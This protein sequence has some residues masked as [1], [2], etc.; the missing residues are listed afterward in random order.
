MSQAEKEKLLLPY[1][2]FSPFP[3]SPP[4]SLL[5]R[6]LEVG[7]SLFALCL[8]CIWHVCWWVGGAGFPSLLFFGVG[9]DS[10][11][12]AGMPACHLPSLSPPSHT[13]PPCRKKGSP[14]L[15]L[16]PPPSP[17]LGMGDGEGRKEKGQGKE[18][19]FS[20]HMGFGWIGQ[21]GWM[22][23]V[24]ILWMGMW[25]QTSLLIMFVHYTMC[26]P[27]LLYFP[28]TT[29]HILP[30]LLHTCCP[31]TFILTPASVFLTMTMLL[32]ACLLLCY[33]SPS[34]TAFGIAPA[35][36]PFCPHA[37]YTTICPLLCACLVYICH[38]ILP[39]LAAFLPVCPLPF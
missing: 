11:Q 38:S 5:S 13:P 22:E 33:S 6:S 27:C 9:G 31:H 35:C 18:G 20:R 32:P 26:V 21:F 25:D 36:L 4:L 34:R 2:P 3:S 16:L 12:A 14:L 10:S 17:S 24:Q 1:L 7:L 28:S 37:C 29:P 15:F 39:F 8:V 19:G 30:P 23:F